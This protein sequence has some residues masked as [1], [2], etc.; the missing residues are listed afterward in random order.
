M[1]IMINYRPRTLALTTAMTNVGLSPRY[2][3]AR[4]SSAQILLNML[5]VLVE[6]FA[7]VAVLRGKVA[8]KDDMLRRAAEQSFQTKVPQQHCVRPLLA[9]AEE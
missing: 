6:A 3:P 9:A 8:H 1:Q 4:P 7:V 5:H 2:R